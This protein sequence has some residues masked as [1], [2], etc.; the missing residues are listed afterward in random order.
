ML[1]KGLSRVLLAGFLLLLGPALPGQIL[2]NSLLQKAKSGDI[3][4]MYR[5]AEAYELGKGAEVNPAE[6][7]RWYQR[8]AHAGDSAAQTKIALFYA[9][10]VGVP[11]EP[12]TA[13]RWLIRAAS[14]G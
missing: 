1:Y 12:D 7:A 4:S 10:G 11:K 13:A 6:A 8:A 3:A 9:R 5:V 2:D 14:S